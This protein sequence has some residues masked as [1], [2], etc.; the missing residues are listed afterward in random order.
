MSVLSEPWIDDSTLHA[1]VEY[2]EALWQRRTVGAVELPV[3]DVG[4]GDPCVFVPILEHLEFVYARQIRT[5]SSERRVIRR[6]NRTT[7]TR[8]SCMTF[9][10]Q[11][12]SYS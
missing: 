1:D 4:E 3:I 2:L 9:P 10:F 11:T 7:D 12:P 8:P 6:P 5:L